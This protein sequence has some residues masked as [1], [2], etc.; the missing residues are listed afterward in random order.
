MT[1]CAGCAAVRNDR[2]ARPLTCANTILRTRCAPQGAQGLFDNHSQN[3][4]L[5]VSDTFLS[6]KLQELAGAQNPPARPLTCGNAPVRRTPK[7][8]NRCAATKPE[9]AEPSP[10]GVCAHLRAPTHTP[11]YGRAREDHHHERNAMSE[12]IDT[13]DPEYCTQCERL[14]RE[15]DNA[16]DLAAALE[17]ECANSRNPDVPS[18]AGA[19][20][21]LGASSADLDRWEALAAAAT[22]GPWERDI[23]G[24][25]AFVKQS[26]VDDQYFVLGGARRLDV[27]C[28]FIATSRTAVAALVAALREALETNARLNRRSQIAEAA[29]AD[30]TREPVG[31]RKH[32]SVAA[33]VWERCEESHGLA[34]RTTREGRAEV[35]RLQSRAAAVAD[36][37]GEQCRFDS[38]GCWVHAADLT[39]P[40]GRCALLADVQAIAAAETSSALDPHSDTPATVEAVSVAHSDGE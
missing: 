5:Q 40:D 8:E 19:G 28:E 6:G 14:R 33:E 29:I 9:C 15:R 2:A 16:R 20:D 25:T 10:Y 21:S 37:I 7:N 27:D 24:H 26:G 32:R 4:N 35:E 11:A 30:L 23:T 34:C 38:R 18:F 17:E 31:G 39:T 22:P 13:T 1:P 12:S 3:T 36:A